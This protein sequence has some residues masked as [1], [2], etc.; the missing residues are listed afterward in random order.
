MI[1]GIFET[2]G[3]TLGVGKEKYFLELDDAAEPIA[4]NLQ[5]TTTKTAKVAV[6]PTKVASSSAVEKAEVLT[7]GASGVAAQS[8]AEQAKPATSKAA[9]IAAEVTAGESPAKDKAPKGEASETKTPTGK[10]PKETST[11]KAAATTKADGKSPE[12]VAE[13]ISAT[14]LIVAAIAAAPPAPII[15]SSDNIVEGSKT[16]STDYLMTPIRCSRR[17]PGPSLDAFKTMAKAVNP[18]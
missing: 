1:G 17:R 2:I 13:V 5:G 10:S 15:A 9:D 7:D 14:D 3:S 8:V 18:R 16:F 6:E 12:A 4:K 11:K